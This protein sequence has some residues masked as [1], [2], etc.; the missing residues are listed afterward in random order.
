[1]K[2]LSSILFTL[3]I[4]LIINAQNR[5]TISGYITDAETGES[6]IGAYV[7]SRASG[8]V[9]NNYGF[10]SCS[11]NKGAVEISFSFIG[12]KTIVK[13]VEVSSDM[14]LN[15]ALEPSAEIAEAVVTAGHDSGIRTAYLGALD[16]PVNKIESVPVVLGEVDVLKTVQKMPGV[17]AG[18]EG[19]SGLF[20][21]G[22]GAEE[23]LLLY[24]GVPLY[25]VN[26]LF[27]L[28][29]VYTPEAI[30]KISF[31]KGSFPARYGGRISS[32]LDVRSNDGNLEK[33]SGS[34]SVGL[35]TEKIH[36]EGPLFDR[37][38]SYSVTLRAT[39]TLLFNP[40][41]VSSAGK[42]YY[43]YDLN[44][45][46]V[47]RFG[48]SDKIYV[49]L[50]SGSDSY[51]V[52]DKESEKGFHYGDDYELY[53]DEKNSER[54]LNHTWGNAMAAVRWNHVFSS[55]LFM[56]ASVS[57]NQFRSRRYD[58]KRYRF[59]TDDVRMAFLKNNETTSKAG[60]YDLN[61]AMDFE[62]SPNKNNL[63]NFGFNATRHVFTPSSS[64][65]ALSLTQGDRQ[66][67][68]LDNGFNDKLEGGELSAYA[69]DAIS[70]GKFLLVNAGLRTTIF[71]TQGRNYPSWEPR[72]SAQYRI[73]ETL[74]V[75]T[76]YSRMSQYVHLL[77]SGEMN[78]PT[79]LWLPIT[80]NIKPVFSEVYSVGIYRQLD[81]GWDI[82]LEGYWKKSY[83]VLDY[84]DGKATKTSSYDWEETVSQ[85]EGKSRGIEVLVEKKTGKTQGWLSYTLSK[86]DRRF[87]DGSINGGKEFPFIY[88]R[89]HNVNLTVLHE[90]S[91][92]CNLDFSWDFCSGNMITLPL[93]VGNVYGSS[94]PIDIPYV[95]A[96]NNYRVS[97]S[98][99][100]DISVEL[101]KQKKHGVRKWS[102]G[103]YNVYGRRNPNVIDRYVDYDVVDGEFAPKLVVKKMSLLVFVPSVSYTYDF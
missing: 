27:G 2:R 5:A 95:E 16:I 32:I 61:I 55:K 10:Y 101:K 33:L 21:R 94:Y 54:E 71:L 46:L 12:Y 63:V 7:A 4:S 53:E 48:N 90:F 68:R 98:H 96:R 37:K 65:S 73:N 58:E 6:L 24:D 92:K 64:Q 14:L 44:A 77:A 45:K 102:F 57:W 17:Q 70:I 56:D 84:K 86:T 93:R 79:D 83:N 40:I 43:F 87:P 25:N 34:V 52:K 18:M 49:S 80:K 88:D 13:T 82:S 85:G 26:H 15:V 42:G 75:K 47:H 66:P 23:N 19:L 72:L 11:V 30:K 69:E 8:A 28:L 60:V 50:Y 100:L 78:M 67:V 89:R 51:S 31:Y 35:L 103:M 76:G 9:T 29:S 1:M 91:K 99:H 20:V 62:L 97:P 74:S 22:G 39:P 38:T 36:L 41:L 81:K 3:F 59:D